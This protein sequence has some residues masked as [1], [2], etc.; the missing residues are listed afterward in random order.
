MLPSSKMPSTPG[1][2]ADLDRPEVPRLGPDVVLGLP[3]RVAGR[4]HAYCPGEPAGVNRIR[5]RLST[6]RSSKPPSSVRS[7]TTAS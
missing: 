6:G 1:T 7:S 5:S 2:A 3:G 4:G